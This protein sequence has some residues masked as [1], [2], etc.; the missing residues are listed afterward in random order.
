MRRVADRPPARQQGA[1]GG[2]ADGD[3]RQAATASSSRVRVLESAM[4]TTSIRGVGRTGADGLDAW[5]APV[6][7]P[8]CLLCERRQAAPWKSKAALGE[9]VDDLEA[10]RLGHLDPD[11]TAAELPRRQQGRAGPGERVEHHLARPRRQ[12]DA[13]PG[14]LDGERRRVPARGRGPRG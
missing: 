10:V 4:P 14:Q 9:P 1:D 2:G 12:A 7:T 8:V 11:R 5:T 3:E 13:A 6:H